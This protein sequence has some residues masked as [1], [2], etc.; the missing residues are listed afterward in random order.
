MWCLERNIHITAQ[1]FPGAQ[2]TTTDT[3]SRSLKDRTDW[4][5][6][7]VIFQKIDRTFGPLEIDLFTTTV[8][9]LLQLAARSI[10]TVNRCIPSDLD[11][12]E[13]LC[14][15]TLEPHRKS[16]CTNSETTSSNSSCSSSME[17][18]ALVSSASQN[19]NRLSQKNACKDRIEIQLEPN[20]NHA[21]SGCMAYLRER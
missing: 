5:L 3:E 12:Y 2:N 15:P 17:R 19:A 13:R 21:S 14:Q 9:T 10:C 7:P 8:P 1:H 6:N 18:T 20:L 11:R 16:S 4:K